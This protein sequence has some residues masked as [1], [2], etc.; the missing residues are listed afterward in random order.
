MIFKNKRNWCNIFFFRNWTKYFQA[1][2]FIKRNVKELCLLKANFPINSNHFL[3]SVCNRLSLLQLFKNIYV[4]LIVSYSSTNII[5]EGLVT[6]IHLTIINIY[7]VEISLQSSFYHFR[8]EKINDGPGLFQRIQ[9]RSPP[10]I[11]LNSILLLH[12][13]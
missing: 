3:L 10:A 13:R 7:R 11:D 6:K 12:N 5:N 8:L 9:Q 1:M 2:I 4:L